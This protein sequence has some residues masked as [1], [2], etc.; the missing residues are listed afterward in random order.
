MRMRMRNRIGGKILFGVWDGRGDLK[1][2][3]GG[4]G[5][6]WFEGGGEEDEVMEWNGMEFFRV[7]VYIVDRYDEEEWVEGWMDGWVYTTAVRWQ[8]R[9]RRKGIKTK[10]KIKPTPRSY[11]LTVSPSVTSTPPS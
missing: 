4:G 10:T 5:N 1:M 11:L 7:W 3:G 6:W 8:S 9:K 2:D